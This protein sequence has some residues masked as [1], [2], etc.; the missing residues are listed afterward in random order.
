M[1][2]SIMVK[3][4]LEMKEHQ[5]ESFLSGIKE[6]SDQGAQLCASCG[7]SSYCPISSRLVASMCVSY[8]YD[9]P[10]DLFSIDNESLE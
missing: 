10:I 1:V 7:R 8:R 5:S 6:S 9:V 2:A 3:L 4:F